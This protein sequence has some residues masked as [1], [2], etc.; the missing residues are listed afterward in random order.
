MGPSARHPGPSGG[1]RLAARTEPIDAT[2]AF[3]IACYRP[4]QSHPPE[5]DNGA[6]FARPGDGGD[7]D[8]DKDLRLR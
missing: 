4:A 5:P 1:G 8:G 7:G 3:R 6:A 2:A